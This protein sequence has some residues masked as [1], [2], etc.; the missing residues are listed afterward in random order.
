MRLKTAKTLFG[1][2]GFANNI[3][4][5]AQSRVTNLRMPRIMSIIALTTT[6]T[7]P[8]NSNDYSATRSPVVPHVD[9]K[10]TRN[11]GNCP[12]TYISTNAAGVRT[13]MLWTDKGVGGGEPYN[14]NHIAADGWRPT[15]LHQRSRTEYYKYSTTILCHLWLQRKFR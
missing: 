6:E 5:M 12:D 9:S 13:N 15:I 7:C 11:E 4:M 14:K 1:L 10:E 3:H 8:Q 2:I